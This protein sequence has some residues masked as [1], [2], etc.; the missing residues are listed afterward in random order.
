MK[1]RRLYLWSTVL[2][3]SALAFIFAIAEVLLRYSIVRNVPANS[4]HTT[5]T[6]YMPVKTRPNWH[7][8]VWN[9]PIVT[10]RFGLRDEP[11][12]S[13]LPQAGEIR[14]LSVGDSIAFGVGIPASSN[15]SKIA[16]GMLNRKR[17]EG[18]YRI[19]N[20]GGQGY[21]PSGYHV[22][23]KHE[24]L[25]LQPAIVVIEIELCNDVTDEALLYWRT[26][27]QNGSLDSIRGGRY[28]MGWDG[29]ML[30]TCALGPYFFEKTYVYTDLLRR[31]LNLRY[32]MHPTEPFRS[33]SEKGTSY[34]S[35]GF[36]RYLLDNKRI[37]SGWSRMFAALE[38]TSAMLK[39]RNI[40]FLLMI[41]PSEY[42]YSERSAAWQSYALNLVRRARN[43]ASSRQLPF[44]DMT[45][46]I[47]NGGGSRL[48]IDFAHLTVEGNKVVGEALF[49]RL[50]RSYPKG[51]ASRTERSAVN[52]P[53]SAAG[54]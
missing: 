11:D 25:R 28:V 9:V 33:Q 43:L 10:N 53:R 7:G 36:D 17:G 18:N 35:L 13:Q 6:S 27:P 54:R 22:Y 3:I 1:K 29:N 48:F 50:Q 38:Q 8:A 39:E 23:L 21:S 44:I 2:L 30:A 5:E 37:E 20:A 15:Y 4:C 24:G 46:A 26:D 12:F 34:Y 31:F 41:M 32:R 19:I 47:R 40:E 45:D 16:E 52:M 51:G 14:I 42:I 49:D